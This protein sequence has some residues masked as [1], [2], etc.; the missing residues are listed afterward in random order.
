MYAVTGITGKVG[1]AVAR[2][3]LSA[4]QRVRAV[5]RDAAKG[6]A[7]ASLGCDIAVADSADAG[8]LA[9]AF[10]GTQG[11]FAMLPPIFDPAPGFPEAREF[12]ASIYSALAAAKPNKVVALST[13]GADALQPNL[14]NGLGLMEDALKTLPMPVSFLRAAWFM[15]NATWDIASA[16][17]GSIQSYL[18]PLDRPVP[19]IATDDVGRTAAALLQEEWNGPRVVELEGAQRGSPNALADA[20]AKVLARPVRAQAVPRDQWESIFRAQGMKNPTPRMQMLDG[21]NAGWIDFANRGAN[22]RKG[23]IGIDQ[24]VATMIQRAGT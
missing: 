21:F 12:I 23:C 5:V 15:E 19:M 2:S 18:Q 14:L 13:I 10:E 22:A 7:W 4:D 3:L 1:A 24:A 17:N 20:F 16:R 11:V 8:A 6:A 9:K